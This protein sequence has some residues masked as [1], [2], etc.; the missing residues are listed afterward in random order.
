MELAWKGFYNGH[1]LKIEQSLYTEGFKHGDKVQIYKHP[2]GLPVLRI[3]FG[4][5]HILAP[6]I[7]LAYAHWQTSEF[8]TTCRYMLLYVP[9]TFS[10]LD[11]MYI[12]MLNSSTSH[13]GHIL[14]VHSYVVK[15]NIT[16]QVGPRFIWP[17]QNPFRLPYRR[18]RTPDRYVYRSI[19]TLY[20][21]LNCDKGPN[22]V[23]NRRI[24][25]GI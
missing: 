15:I 22:A 23:L 11:N 25:K 10:M 24:S 13:L 18:S 8:P 16:R 7:S 2:W 21:Q 5:D 3:C 19:G 20:W 17:N 9:C 6:K 14:R 4:R 1:T 12:F